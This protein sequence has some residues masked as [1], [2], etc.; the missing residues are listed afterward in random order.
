MAKWYGNVLVVVKYFL[1]V[2]CYDRSERGRNGFDGIELSRE[3]V[4]GSELP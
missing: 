2:L 3:G 1:Q 4:P